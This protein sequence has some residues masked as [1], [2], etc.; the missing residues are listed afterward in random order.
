M[1]TVYPAYKSYEKTM[2]HLKSLGLETQLSK[3]I[4]VISDA[5]DYY[6][7]G[8]MPVPTQKLEKPLTFISFGNAEKQ[9]T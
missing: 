9:K 3:V 8:L 7:P 2:D 5:S 1:V 6:E 4:Y